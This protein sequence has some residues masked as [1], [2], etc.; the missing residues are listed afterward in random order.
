MQ[1]KLIGALSVLA[2]SASAALMQDDIATVV[3]T[4][5]IT[6][7]FPEVVVYEPD[8]GS[9]YNITAGGTESGANMSDVTTFA[10]MNAYNYMLSP[11]RSRL[12]FLMTTG[13]NETINGTYYVADVATGA[14]CTKLDPQD[15]TMN[16]AF[17]AM[18]SPDGS[19]LAVGHFNSM[20][21]GPQPTPG[22]IVVY[23]LVTNGIV[24]RLDSTRIDNT[25]FGNTPSIGIMMHD[26][27]D[28]GIVV[29]PTCVGCEP[30]LQGNAQ[31]WN[32]ADDS[33]SDAKIPFNL[34]SQHLSNG[35]SLSAIMDPT[36][37]NNPDAVGMLPVPN[38]VSYTPAS[39]DPAVPAPSQVVYFNPNNIYIRQVSWV[40]DGQAI[41]IQHANTADFF[42]PSDE[43]YLLLRDGTQVPLTLPTTRQFL[44]PTS[45]GWVMLDTETTTYI[46][47]RLSGATVEEIALNALYA[48]YPIVVETPDF[49]TSVLPGSVF[50]VVTAP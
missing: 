50:P 12:I 16:N 34:T 10:G 8:T 33:L 3:F 28:D 18:F 1:W 14:C 4:D 43:A 47:Y 46:Y 40:A 41:L 13:M 44:A 37:P 2:L 35:E 49:G 5:V 7:P 11:D 19:Q 17:S 42:A 9:L 25:V 6:A 31:L 38:V 23:D 20:Q 48:G 39:S 15:P 24:A 45:D 27:T 22:Q 29:S 32:P 30:P 36:F 21:M 26:W